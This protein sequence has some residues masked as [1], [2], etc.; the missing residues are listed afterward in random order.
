MLD[1]VRE[2][3]RIVHLDHPFG[4]GVAMA[5][6][7]PATMMGLAGAGRIVSGA[8]ANLVLLTART[9]NEVT[10]RPQ[11]DRVILAGGRPSHAQVPPYEALT[12]EAA[13][14]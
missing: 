5:G 12:G 2:A 8:P 13:P 10:A 11:L 3:V 4:D 1:T 14:W 6:P 9:L 7:V